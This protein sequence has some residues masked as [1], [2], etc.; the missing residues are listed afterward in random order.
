MNNK[1][2]AA[3][4][5]GLVLGMLLGAATVVFALVMAGGAL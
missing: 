3:F 2:L 1:E 5:S 4:G